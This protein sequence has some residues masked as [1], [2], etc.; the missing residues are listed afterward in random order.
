MTIRNLP[1]AVFGAR[2]D[3]RSDIASG[4][5]NRWNAGVQFASGEDAATISVLDVI[6]QDWWDGEGVTAKR[7]S[8]A[9]RSIGDRPVT[10]AINSPGGD[11]FEGLAIYNA[12]REHPNHV[13]VKILGLAASAASVIAMAGDEVQ[14]A[15]AGFLM[16]HN[17]WVVAMGDRNAFREVADWLEPFDAAAVDIYAARSGLDPKKIAA[18]CDKETW[19]SGQ[20]AVDQG[21]ADS[22]LATDEIASGAQQSAVG[23]SLRAE[24][25]FDMLAQKAGVTRS[26]AREL[27]AS[28]KGGKPGAA[29]Q[30]MQDAAIAA[31]V[32][33]LLAIAKAL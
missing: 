29:S 32:R 13:T 27:L 10:V 5:L 3:V 2:P 8:A 20:Q 19:I 23:R 33:N 14:I 4:A 9:L 28:L 18:M 15:R 26:E 30:G 16:I 17:T 11:F 25:Q 24:R 22:L 7:I 1:S 21:F 12:L 31:E 6:G